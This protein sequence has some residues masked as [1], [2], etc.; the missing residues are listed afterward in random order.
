MATVKLRILG[1]C[2]IEVGER[3][4]GPEAPQLF[5]LL[6]YLGMANGRA[7][8]RTELFEL[9][10]P[11][12][13][14]G[15]RASHN[16]R[17]LLYR[18][19]GMGVAIETAGDRVRLAEIVT[20]SLTHFESLSRQ[21][22]LSVPASDLIVFPSYE[23]TISP[24]FADWLE[25]TRSQGGE[26][27]KNM[28]RSDFRAYHRECDWESL[29]SSGNTLRALDAWTEEVLSNVAEA[30]LMQGRKHD[31][32]DEIDAFLRECELS[33][34]SVLRQL[35][36]RIARAKEHGPA[37]ES[38]FK[39]R[40]PVMMALARQW[41]AATENVYQI[42]M[43]AGPPGIGKS[44]VLN[45]FSA[46]V[47]IHKGQ[48]LSYRCDSS[49][50]THPHSFFK[51]IVPKLRA[52]RGSLGA[53]PELQPH[54]DRLALSEAPPSPIEPTSLEATRSELQLALIDL[55]EAVA[56]ESPLLLCID[57]VHLLDSAS[58]AVIDAICQGDRAIALMVVCSS[59]AMDNTGFSTANK[60]VQ[61]HRLFPLCEADSIAVLRHLLP[62]HSSE[63]EFLTSC[64]TR[65]GGNPYYLQAIASSASPD[66][67]P[68]SIPF[69]IRV[70]AST[71]Y[72]S[73]NANARTLFEAC[74][75]LG[76]LASLQRVRAIAAIDGAPLL[77]ALRSLEENDL[78]SFSG[79][80]L[81]CAH[82]LLEEAC[83]P[84]IPSAVAAALH[85][86]IAQCLER[87][88]VVQG[89]SAPLAWAAAE[90]WIA[91]GD[92]QS[93]NQLL[94]RCA[95]QAAALGEPLLAARTLHHIPQD[96][97]APL[98]RLSLLR[99]IV[100]YEEAAADSEHVGSSL[101]ALLRASIALPCSREAIQETELRIIEADLRLGCEPSE[102][103]TALTA[104]I[105]DPSAAAPLRAR[106][107]IRLLIAADMNLDGC[108]AELT[109][110]RLKPVLAALSPDEPL[111][112]R[113][114]LIYET[115]F[116]DQMRAYDL[117]LQL[118]AS[119]PEPALAQTAVMAR[120]NAAFALLRMGYRAKASTILLADY[121]Y[122]SS[123]HVMSEAAYSLLLLA[124][125]SLC[126]GNVVHAA[127][128]LR[129]ATPLIRS[130]LNHRTV[131]T[132]YY[133]A[134]AS[135]A[136]LEGR[137]DDAQA[138]ISEARERYPAIGLRYRAVA[139]SLS[140]R[141][142]AAR[143]SILQSDPELRELIRLYG[144]GGHLGGQDPIVEA[145]W[146]ADQ[147]QGSNL[148]GSYLSSRRRELTPPEASLRLSTKR[149]KIWQE[150]EDP[151]H[152]I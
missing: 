4:I 36:G 1:E 25:T 111:R 14:D 17:Q 41:A 107:G 19:R 99:A 88:C 96:K 109:L 45:E 104:L 115:V 48:C 37:P 24:Q 21:E 98:E 132:G 123:H 2:V 94:Q 87:E 51:L 97:L 8:H 102:S 91:A 136:L 63:H 76:R 49:D 142:R 138:L 70:F 79:G 16:L 137:L 9:L 95:A 143:G 22:R 124:D 13:R 71:C 58:K 86:R 53:S 122:M 68:D 112:L 64:A 74:L 117:A 28:I 3:R 80:E 101:R 85:E 60:R 12:A 47:S 133:S 110:N 77:G 73:L 135:F 127:S 103:I 130:T 134:A 20:S 148:L 149:D 82:A 10:F 126:D 151:T 147:Q 32:L 46:Y 52:L 139:L 129:D 65:A 114:E 118:L 31:A 113:A 116:G 81:A 93:A 6:L 128:W 90:S 33:S 125:I 18:L 26:R 50:R 145:L 66:T 15:G 84:L 75:L 57:D 108:L 43:V 92:V 44:R 30:L 141:V 35:R 146:L 140:L 62:K 152:P 7:V 100:E 42:A 40:S 89:Y 5:A 23:P 144:L 150:A 59:R 11:G 54:L 34:V 69:D 131:Q 61:V 105:N 67:G 38:P 106:A 119:Q 56:S 120:R 72:Y 121:S 83:R 29:V 39:G 55:I 27:I 78:I